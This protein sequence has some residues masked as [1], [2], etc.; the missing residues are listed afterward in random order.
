LFFQYQGGPENAV[1]AINPSNKDASVKLPVHYNIRIENN[2][3]KV[4]D[5]RVLYAK[6]T[7]GLTFSSNKI[8]RT[9][10]LSPQSKNKICSTLI[11]DFN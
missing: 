11:A 7:Q 3:F 10:D 8:I 4:F 1:I 9:H 2:I 6:S 5:Y